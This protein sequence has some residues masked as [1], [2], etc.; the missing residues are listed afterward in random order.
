MLERMS[1]RI[2]D[3]R[4]IAFEI[5]YTIKEEVSSLKR[6]YGIT[7]N[8]AIVASGEVEG[9]KIYLRMIKN[10]C[11]NV[12]IYSNEYFLSGDASTNELIQLIQRLN[13]DKGVHGILV[14]MP[15]PEHIGVKEVM[16][17][18]SP[19]KDVDCIHPINYGRLLTDDALAPCTPKGIMVLLDKKNI[20]L[21]GK[22]VVIVSHSITVGKPLALMMLNKD[23]TVHVC[24]IFTKNLK[25]HTK[26]ADILI[27]AAGVPNLIK[28]DM[29]K[30]DSI[31]IDVGMNRV[32]KKL[33]GDVDFEGVKNKVNGITPVPGGV[34]PMTVTMV[35]K[36][37][38]RL[39]K[40]QI[41]VQR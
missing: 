12:N 26:R 15:L 24:H 3:G 34:G 13:S 22:E 19:K 35:L 18:I 38:I 39:F 21:K 31:I 25:A 40:H 4:K 5:Q 41:V 11:Q 2:I 29:V 6:R 27:V 14:E 23:A 28:E 20:E 32:G 30:R 37:T 9:S 7:P 33:C 1:G 10:G 16:E 17:S 8:L 36:N